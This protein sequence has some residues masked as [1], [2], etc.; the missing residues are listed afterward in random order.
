MKH[1]V[2]PSMGLGMLLLAGL[3]YSA[4]TPTPPVRTQETQILSDYRRQ[5]GYIPKALLMMSAREKVLTCFMS[6]GHAIFDDG[7]LSNKERSL[8]AL[9]AA[10]ALKSPECIN[11]HSTRARLAG[12]TDDE[13]AQTVLIAGLISNT[14]ALHIAYESAPLPDER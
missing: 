6:Y 14:S 8:V 10:T 4:T 11:A 1:R 3:A 9:A 5:H 12:A 2:R 13:V 7:P